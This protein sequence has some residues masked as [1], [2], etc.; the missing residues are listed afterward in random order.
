VRFYARRDRE[1]E[2]LAAVA[3]ERRVDDALL[4]LRDAIAELYESTEPGPERDLRRA[5]LE[6]EARERLAALPLEQADAGDVAAAARLND[7]C[8]SIA[9]TYAADVPAWRARLAELGGSLPAFIELARSVEDADD[10]RAAI[11]GGDAEAAAA[12][13]SAVGSEP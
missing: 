7:A 11:L 12:G 13:A 4:A 5:A 1:A 2:M 9:A 3:D 8:L 6:T 10:P